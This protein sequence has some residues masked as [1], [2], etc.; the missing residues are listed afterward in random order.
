M[1][2]S[3]KTSFV[4]LVGPAF[5][6]GNDAINP[7]SFTFLRVLISFRKTGPVFLF[8]FEMGFF[9]VESEGAKLTDPGEPHKLTLSFDF[10]L[11]CACRVLR[12]VNQSAT[13]AQSFGACSMLCTLCSLYI[14]I[15]CVVFVPA[16][17]CSKGFMQ[18]LGV[19]G[20]VQLLYHGNNSALQ[21]VSDLP[22]HDFA[23]GTLIKPCSSVMMHHL[24]LLIANL[25]VIIFAPATADCVWFSLYAPEYSFPGRTVSGLGVLRPPEG[26]S[27]RRPRPLLLR[28][29]HDLLAG[30]VRPHQPGTE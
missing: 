21:R 1:C 16:T 10:C 25:T 13:P 28:A 11:F 6:C 20:L 8:G 30:R 26:G 19:S 14:S 24:F 22:R 23:D 27:P 4:P 7:N 12:A 17:A 9:A 5:S 29:E 18:L 3:R 2:K 15:S